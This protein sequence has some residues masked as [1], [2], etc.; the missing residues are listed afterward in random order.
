[1]SGKRR[2]DDRKTVLCDAMECP[3]WREDEFVACMEGL[4]TCPS[5][6][7]DG[8]LSLSEGCPDPD[9]EGFAPDPARVRDALAR[10]RKPKPKRRGARRKG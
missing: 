6:G 9:T 1:M 7:S 8:T 4:D 10:W 3:F 2:E 5:T